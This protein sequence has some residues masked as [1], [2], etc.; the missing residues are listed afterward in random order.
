MLQIG[1]D[2]VWLRVAIYPVHKQVLGVYVSRHRNMLIAEHFISSLIRGNGG[3]GKH[4]ISTD[5]GTWY[6][7]ACKFLKLDHHHIHSSYE[8]VSSKEL[9]SILRIEPRVL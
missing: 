9:C 8:K 7:K 4:S 1:S 6:P 3:D 5:G 2:Y